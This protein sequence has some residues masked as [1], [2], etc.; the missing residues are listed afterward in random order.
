VI[1]ATL[2]CSAPALADDVPVHA[3]GLPEVTVSAPQTITTP[4]TYTV[5]AMGTATGLSLAPGET[6]QSV[7]VVTRQQIEDANLPTALEAVLA[8]P[9]IA[10]VRSDSNRVQLSA[11]GFTIDNLQ[12]DGMSSPILPHWNYGATNMSSAIYERVDVVRGATGLMT[13]N[14]EPS[15]AINF[16]RKQPLGRFDASAMFGAGS[17]GER[18]ANA[19]IS[20]AQVGPHK[21]RT[22]FVAETA[23]AGSHISWQGQ[24]SDTFYGVAAMDLTP[25]TEISLGL[26]YQQD[27]AR[28]FGSGVPLFYSDG[29]RTDFDR[30][31]S[32]NTRWARMNTR[33]TTGLAHLRHRFD[34]HWQLRAALELNRGH[35]HMRNLFRGKF[36]DRDSGH[37]MSQIWRNFDG[38]R[39]RNQ[40]NL[41]LTGPFR[42]LGR[43]HQ[44]VLGWS[45]VIDHNR[46]D[47]H[48]EQSPLPDTGSFFDWRSAPIAEPGWDPQTRPASHRH[49]V[50]SGAYA[51]GRFSLAAPLHLI[52]GVRLANIDIERYYFGRQERYRH[53]NQL[54]PYAGAVYDLDPTYALYGSYTS[55]FKPQF[56]QSAE[57]SLLAPIEGRSLE[58]GIKAAWRGGAL[59]ASAVL[60]ETTQRNLAVPI[61]GVYVR[62]QPDGQASR[63]ARGV[64]VQG[65]EFEL[66]GQLLPRWEIST[67]FTRFIKRSADGR[68]LDSTFP[69]T[70]LKLF[71]TVKLSERITLGGGVDWHN[72]IS[73]NTRQPGG[74][75]WVEQASVALV[76]LMARYQVDRRV[77]LA[78]HVDNLFDRHYYSQVGFYSQGWVGD[79]RRL[80][81]TLRVTY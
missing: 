50:Q 53:R 66:A 64:R 18:R 8:A 10:A 76:N 31:A 34:N 57:G 46:V 21:L 6:P 30:S 9:G 70:Q 29:S 55:I 2:C 23:D 74:D 61:P 40:A 15:A 59:N 77:S 3:T 80:R 26:E 79:P 27:A 68:R 28:G 35:Y 22:R 44:G 54:I 33:S 19:D 20:L 12:F 11:R 41:S 39:Q 52:L 45:K 63:P 81:A 16:I 1:S 58:A 38:T 7:S 4:D 25:R 69:S 49:V 43:Q 17:W 65:I 62:G 67:S 51:A 32:N 37:G 36:P 14:G 47:R 42:L 71:N 24:R 73:R 5:E 72:S 56:A 60:F 78:L 48:M 75:G 13:G